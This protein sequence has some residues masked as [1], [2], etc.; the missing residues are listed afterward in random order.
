MGRADCIDLVGE[1][2]TP[3]Q[4]EQ[5]VAHA[6]ERVGVRPSFSLLAPVRNATPRYNLF[7]ECPSLSLD[8]VARL[9]DTMESELSGNVYYKQAIDLK[10]LQPLEVIRLCGPP[11]SAWTIYEARYL[12][13]GQKAGD[14]KPRLL[15]GTE[16]W[17]SLFAR[18]IGTTAG[19]A[20]PP[21]VAS[22]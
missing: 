13:R 6:F 14:I 7:V 1:K 12:S 5:A 19:Q 3:S 8:V 11:G 21:G 4:A 18:L 20:R 2:L 15:D 9:R 22:W 10:Q 17:T 16:D